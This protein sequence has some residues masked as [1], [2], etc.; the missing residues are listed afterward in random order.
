MEGGG[1]PSPPPRRTLPAPSPTA[2]CCPPHSKP[3]GRRPLLASQATLGEQFPRL[4]K[5]RE[6]AVL[7]S[8]RAAWREQ[9][10]AEG[11]PAV[12]LQLA[13]LLLHLDVHGAALF[14]VP[15]RLLPTLLDLLQ[16]KLPEGAHATL[17][18]VATLAQAA[19]GAELPADAK[20]AAE[21][22]EPMLDDVRQLGLGLSKG[23][24]ADEAKAE[25]NDAPV[26]P[27]PK[28]KRRTAKADD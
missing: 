6:K 19:I 13:L 10:Q 21:E 26:E 28:P 14:P 23:R 5:K 24:E 27:K 12:A 17:A 25:A 20:A 7:A 16:P 1:A 2:R 4:D 18:R 3:I 22:V 11:Q 8:M 15:P 9:L